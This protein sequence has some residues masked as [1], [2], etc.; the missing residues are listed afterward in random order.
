MLQ[1]FGGSISAEAATKKPAAKPKATSAAW[2]CEEEEDGLGTS[3]SCNSTAINKYYFYKLTLMCTSEQRLAHS[4]TGFDSNYDLVVW[5]ID[6]QKS[7]KV[8]VD[9]KPIETWNTGTKGSGQALTFTKGTKF[10]LTKIAT[11]KTFGF[12]AKDE[13]GL[14]YSGRFDV[15]NSVP[16]A[17]KFAAM[18]CKTELK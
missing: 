6:N 4:I 2:D 14:A 5:G 13:E 18:G 3:F 17:A 16:I 1:G 8:R 9:S 12:Q 10:L 11:A 15:R 7:I